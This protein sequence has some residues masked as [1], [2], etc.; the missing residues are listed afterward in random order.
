[1]GYQKE[2]E[3]GRACSR[4]GGEKRCVEVLVGI[5]E[6]NRP[7]GRCRCRWED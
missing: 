6:R 3:M 2:N 5:P 7:L 1:L 4:Y